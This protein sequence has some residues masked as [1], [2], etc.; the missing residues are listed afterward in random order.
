MMI[1]KMSAQGARVIVGGA[2]WDAADAEAQ[3]ALLRDPRARYIPPFDH[4]L[5]W[6]GHASIVDEVKECVRSSSS[7]SHHHRCVASLIII[8]I[9]TTI[10]IIIII[11][12][13]IIIV[14]FIFLSR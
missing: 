8:V 14:S 3:R 4:P 5:I 7:H 1:A 6:E 10:T 9:N 2:N 12:I 13:I 11:I